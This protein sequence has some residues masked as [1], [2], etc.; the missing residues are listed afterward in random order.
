VA[1]AAGVADSTAAWT[2]GAGTFEIT[3]AG[4]ATITTAA[5]GIG[6]SMDDVAAAI[7]AASRAAN[8]YNA[9]EVTYDETTNQYN[10]K[11]SAK[12]GGV[13]AATITDNTGVLAA[14]DVIEIT[15]AA[16]GTVNIL[17]ATAAATALGTVTNA[18]NVKD[19]ARAAFGY[20]SDVDVATE[21]ATMTRTQV[22]AQAGISMLAQANQMPQMAMSL[23]RG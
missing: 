8:D 1:T 14:A 5:L 10:L 17:D 3:F 12:A 16:G 11:I 22:L 21:M 18:I 4:E 6:D 19:T 7:N 20:I 9:A 2:T 15:G 23:L 13:A